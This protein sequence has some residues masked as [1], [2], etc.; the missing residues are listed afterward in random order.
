MR[1]LEDSGPLRPGCGFRLPGVGRPGLM[2]TSALVERRCPGLGG[3]WC[4]EEV[5]RSSEV[6]PWVTA[7]LGHDPRWLQSLCSL[8]T[9]AR[10]PACVRKAPSHMMEPCGPIQM[11]ML[12]TNWF[13]WMLSTCRKRQLGEALP[14]GGH[15]HQ[16][17]PH[18]T[19]TVVSQQVRG[20]A[21][22]TTEDP[23][24]WL[25][26]SWGAVQ[27]SWTLISVL[28]TKAVLRDTTRTK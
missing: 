28:H 5:S 26:S 7:E 10:G 4:W 18:S 13:C 21:V 2:L 22:E 14:G 16:C 8:H 3:R 9:Q 15:G 23:A 17:G 11:P 6:T 1:A 24:S 25:G 19:W 12:D 27:T 20:P